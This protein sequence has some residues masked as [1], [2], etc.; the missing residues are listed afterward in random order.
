MSTVIGTI[1]RI[2]ISAR[3]L[4]RCTSYY[5]FQCGFIHEGQGWVPAE[6]RL[7]R[8]DV[9]AEPVLHR[10]ALLLDGDPL[11]EVRL[12]HDCL[13]NADTALRIPTALL[14]H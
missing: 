8:V 14:S 13:F 9:R 10:L 7:L 5:I 3:F 4:F 6:H 12:D 1:D 2:D 11:P